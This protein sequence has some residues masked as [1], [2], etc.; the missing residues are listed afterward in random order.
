M[1]KGGGAAAAVAEA[2]GG[3][4][5][6]EATGQELTDGVVPTALDVELDPR[7]GLM[8]RRMNPSLVCRVDTPH[9]A[10][11]AYSSSSLAMVA[12]DSGARPSEA[13]LRSLPSSMYG[14]CSVL[15][16]A[17]RRISRWV[18]GSTPAYTLARHDPLGS[19]ST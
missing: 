1:P 9:G 11:A 3:V 6:V 4:A 17:L 19:C 13:C 10:I 16:V 7:A 12:P 15:A 8:V 2:G 14:C 18:I 5:Q